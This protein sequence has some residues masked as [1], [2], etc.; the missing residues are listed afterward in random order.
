MQPT[1]NDCVASQCNDITKP[2]AKTHT[3]NCGRFGCP[4]VLFM[5]LAPTGPRSVA[6]S[7]TTRWSARVGFPHSPIRL[8]VPTRTTHKTRRALRHSLL[9]A[10]ALKTAAAKM[11][12]VRAVAGGEQRRVRE[13]E[14]SRRTSTLRMYNPNPPRAADA[15]GEEQ[16]TR[17]NRSSRRT[18]TP[19]MYNPNPSSAAYARR[20]LNFTTGTCTILECGTDTGARVQASAR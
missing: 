12:L 4:A 19:K 15:S 14:S 18:S 7:V 17:G 2:A 8:P 16:R 6:L 11:K 9:R 20:P 10:W 5:P 3:L 1:D 13:N